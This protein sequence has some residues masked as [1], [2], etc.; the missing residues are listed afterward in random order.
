MSFPGFAAERIAPIAGADY[1][2]FLLEQFRTARWRIWASIFIVE[3]RNEFD[4]SLSVR[5]FLNEFEQSAW[6]GV[7]VRLLVG[8]SDTLDIR[9][10]NAV[11][12]GYLAARSLAV[13]RYRPA[14]HNV[15][16]HS[17]YIVV[18]ADRVIVGGHNWS[19]GSL[20]QHQQDSVAV[21]S[22]DLNRLLGSEFLA[23]WR[24]A[25]PVEAP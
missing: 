3:L 21:Y 5:R 16:T 25:P 20:E 4:V 23:L 2:P 8:V 22:T 14:Q 9:L 17:K 7:D 10:S 6:R 13:R 15:S 11:A 1:A 19:P 18:D 12:T 24:E